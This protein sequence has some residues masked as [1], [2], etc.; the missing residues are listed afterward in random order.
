MAEDL[1]KRQCTAR[2]VGWLQATLSERLL[3][4]ASKLAP[5]LGES[6]VDS[7][8]LVM[9]VVL[10]TALI[11]VDRL[12]DPATTD[13]QART[14][15]EDLH[16]SRLAAAS[17][18]EV[19]SVCKKQFGGPAHGS[20][21]LRTGVVRTCSEECFLTAM[22]SPEVCTLRELELTQDDARGRQ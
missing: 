9:R 5:S 12:L 19:C 17:V 8:L 15:V 22:R 2:L 1:V 13:E 18:Q 10:S 4:D 6:Q 7:M 11:G 20:V 21:V 14:Y 16:N 3:A